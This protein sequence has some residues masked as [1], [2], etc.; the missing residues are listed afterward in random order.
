M[1]SC[2]GCSSWGLMRSGLGA[3]FSSPINSC[4][5][6]V[7]MPLWGWN[8]GQNEILFSN[9]HTSDFSS[10]KILPFDCL[11]QSPSLLK[12]LLKDWICVS[13]PPK[14]LTLSCIAGVQYMKAKKTF[15]LN[16]IF[17]LKTLVILFNAKERNFTANLVFLLW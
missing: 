11:C 4:F 8:G 1:I 7:C 9:V 5:T 17:F 13:I 14:D 3:A 6:K 10:F 12:L 16:K 15:P 2:S